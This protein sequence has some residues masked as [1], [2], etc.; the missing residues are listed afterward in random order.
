[1]IKKWLIFCAVVAGVT[2]LIY[3][4]VSMH[5]VLVYFRDNPGSMTPRV[6]Y[7]VGMYYF[8]QDQCPQQME[9]F[10]IIISSYPASDWAGE[11]QFRIAQCYETA[12]DWENA[13]AAYQAFFE[14][15]PNSP[16][17]EVAQKDYDLI[18]FK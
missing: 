18:K 2:W 8:T 16:F 15:Y 4:N 17:K 12:R 10:N 7:Y 14:N 13:K 11:A 5:D 1:M 3:A 6:E 9:A